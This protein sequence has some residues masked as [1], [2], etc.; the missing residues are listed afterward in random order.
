M[1]PGG[2]TF[3]GRIHGISPLKSAPGPDLRH[4]SAA[5]LDPE[6]KQPRNARYREASKRRHYVA[7]GA[8]ARHV[9]DKAGGKRQ[10]GADRRDDVADP[11][12]QVQKR[13]FRLGAGLPWTATLT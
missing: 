5:L 3:E 2:R 11:V 13:A 8:T 6:L 9:S 10:A 1:F 7:H 12:D 4:A